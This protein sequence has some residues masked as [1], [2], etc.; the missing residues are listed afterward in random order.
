MK[1]FWANSVLLTLLLVELVTGFFGLVSGSAGDA[2]FIAV[3]RIAGF[4][5]VAVLVWKVAIIVSSLRR[6]RSGRRQYASLTL[7]SLLAVTLSLGFAWSYAGPV[8]VRVVQR[9]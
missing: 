2:I 6:R 7:L 5:I 4:A 3:H 1:S 8:H 9:R